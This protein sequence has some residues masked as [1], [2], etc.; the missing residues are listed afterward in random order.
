MKKYVRKLEVTVQY[1]QTMQMIHTLYDLLC[2]DS[3]LSLLY[4]PVLLNVRGKV[5]PV[6]IFEYKVIRVLRFHSV[7][8]GNDIRMVCFLENED[9]IFD[10]FELI[11]ADS[12]PLQTLDSDYSFGFRML[13]LVNLGI[14]SFTDTL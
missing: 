7:D 13:G 6:A 10:I 2:Y 14:M 4:G 5:T 1:T 3:S 9:L 8:H 11:I 12:V